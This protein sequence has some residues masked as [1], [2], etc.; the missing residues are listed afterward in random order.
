MPAIPEEDNFTVAKD[1]VP[2]MTCVKMH[3]A[4]APTIVLESQN[5][6]GVAHSL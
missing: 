1:P 6:F 5:S 3:V 2:Q 4:S